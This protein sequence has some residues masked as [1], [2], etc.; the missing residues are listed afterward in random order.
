M[1]AYPLVFPEETKMTTHKPGIPGRARAAPKAPKRRKRRASA[2]PPL[3]LSVPEAGRKYF[4]LS[5]NG[6]YGAAA[7]GEIPTIKVG[8]LRRVPVR[9]ME[10]LLDKAA[11]SVAA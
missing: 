9:A 11:R 5:K 2:E 8:K 1:F 4:G 3:T 6:S 7:R 10:A